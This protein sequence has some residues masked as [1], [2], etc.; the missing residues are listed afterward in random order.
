MPDPRHAVRPFVARGPSMLAALLLA[1]VPLVSPPLPVP[2]SNV[3][4]DTPPI[5]QCN[6]V[7]PTL[8]IQDPPQL[9]SQ[10]G[11]LNV[12]LHLTGDPDPSNIEGMCWFYQYP[13][14]QGI[15]T[16]WNPPALHVHQGDKLVLTLVNEMLRPPTADAR[17]A[18]NGGRNEEDLGGWDSERE[19]SPVGLMC[20][21]PQ[22]VATPTPDASTGRIFAYH[23]SPWNETSM[24]F[25][26]LTV[27]PRK[28]SDDVVDVLMCPRK[29]SA[30]PS[31]SFTYTIDIPRDEPP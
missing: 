7:P 1:T 31:R 14:Q 29:T 24:H 8:D 4:A 28:P 9:Y 10:H 15:A 20:G 3:P 12:T 11:V 25:H 5:A 2:R 21:Q 26:G 22:A 30:D 23:R 18:Q 19:R 17:T 16:Y 27:S 13:S 6:A